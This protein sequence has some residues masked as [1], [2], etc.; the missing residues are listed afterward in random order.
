MILISLPFSVTILTMCSAVFFRLPEVHFP[1]FS[2][3]S[4]SLF[5]FSFSRGYSLFWEAADSLGPLG[6]PRGELKVGAA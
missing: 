2:F 4:L 3:T 5:F 1:L 6:L